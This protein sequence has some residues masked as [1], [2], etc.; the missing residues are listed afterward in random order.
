MSLEAKDTY[1]GAFLNL[2]QITIT[3][4]IGSYI[5]NIT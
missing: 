2:K 1:R 4:L 5:E 3:N